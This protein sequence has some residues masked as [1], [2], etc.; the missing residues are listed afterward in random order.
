MPTI[1]IV[2]DDAVIRGML[3][4]VFSEK[5]DCHT[6]STAEEAFQYLEVENYAAILTDI[7]MPGLTGIE[8]LKRVQFRD[9]ETPVILISGKGNEQD[10][11]QLVDLG[12]FAYVSKPFKLIEIEEVVAQAVL[13]ASLRK[14]SSYQDE[15]NGNTS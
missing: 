3:Y 11:Q 6:A 14:L 10:P 1:L 9:S 5:Y 8:L 13:K 12:A 2:D 15:K 7:A 4:E